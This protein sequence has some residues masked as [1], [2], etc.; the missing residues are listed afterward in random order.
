MNV[1]KLVR[2]IPCLALAILLAACSGGS[3]ITHRASESVDA[4]QT[5]VPTITT[6]P[7]SV[8]VKVGIAATFSVVA[9]GAAPLTYQWMKNGTAVAGATGASYSAPPAQLTD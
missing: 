1:K 5:T 7:S 2:G 6:Q 9:S 8:A 3:G 4:A